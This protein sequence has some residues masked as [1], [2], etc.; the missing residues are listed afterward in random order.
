MTPSRV[1][2]HADAS[3]RYLV[4][5]ALQLLRC[6]QAVPEGLGGHAE[7]HVIGLAGEHRLERR[8][9]CRADAVH[10]REEALVVGDCA[11]GNDEARM[12]MG[13]APG[14]HRVEL[15]LHRGVGRGREHAELA[16]V[17]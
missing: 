10:H 16:A 12:V 6:L 17:S 15:R 8:E 13:D 11:V 1:G 2:A 4:E 7:D 3:L 5:F 14:P 9:Q